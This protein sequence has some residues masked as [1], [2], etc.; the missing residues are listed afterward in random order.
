MTSYAICKTTKRYECLYQSNLTSLLDHPE[1]AQIY[2]VTYSVTES[3]QF[4]VRQNHIKSTHIVLF[5]PNCPDK[6]SGP[7]LITHGSQG[8]FN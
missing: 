2:R 4:N 5:M 7:N 1:S 3:W 8:C 6:I